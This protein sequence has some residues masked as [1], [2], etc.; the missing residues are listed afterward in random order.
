MTRLSPHPYP[1]PYIGGVSQH[2]VFE[3]TQTL[4]QDEFVRFVQ[5]RQNSQIEVITSY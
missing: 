4:T 5:E 1:P 3:S 2:L